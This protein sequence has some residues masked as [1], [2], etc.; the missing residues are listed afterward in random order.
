[1]R[2]RIRHTTEFH[3]VRPV[4]LHTH[5]VMLRPRSTVE[6][7]LIDFAL[8]LDPPGRISWGLDVFDNAIAT[9][10]FATSADRLTISSHAVVEQTAPPWPV[11]LLD[12][13]VHHYPFRYSDDDARDLGPCLDPLHPD[14]DGVLRAWARGFIHADPTDTLSLLKDLNAGMLD[15]VQYRVREEEG[16]QAPLETL[17]LRSGSCRD[18]AALFMECARHLG[19]GARAVSGY[20]HDP[21]LLPGQSASTHGWAEVYLPGAG[22]ITFD[23]TQRTM[24]AHAL[25]A[26]AVGLN[27]DR[28]PPITGHFSGGI[29]DFREMD[30]R[31]HVDLIDGDA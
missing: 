15:F 3:Y 24:G 19:F 23:P 20:V 4:A 5:R 6:Q 30:V 18:I 1:M 29:A 28:V 2:Y 25:I 22:W 31:V 10:D 7:T 14:P 17:Q 11:L 26:V 12:P 13:S 21:D 9:I 16:T 27:N 8:T